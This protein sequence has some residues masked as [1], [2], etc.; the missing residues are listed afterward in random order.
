LSATRAGPPAAD[1]LADRAWSLDATPPADYD[2][3]RP[4]DYAS[5]SLTGIADHF[6]TDKGS[7]KHRYTEVYERYLAPLRARTG[8]RLLE[9]GVACGASLKMWSKYFRDAVVVGVD[10]REGCAG[11]CRGYPAISIRIADARAARQPE[12]FDVIIDDGS[13]IS[14]DIV[15]IFRVNWP[16]L[17]PGGLYFIED[18]KCTHNPLYPR[19]TAIRA[20]PE[21]FERR[22][23]VEFI[24]RQLVEMDWGRGEVESLHFHRELAVLRK[25]QR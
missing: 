23:F 4:I 20:A 5:A 21:R 14:A 16:S 8:V 12:S 7:I 1:A 13:H 2:P 24:D 9:I 3:P 10:L 6:K 25:A 22:H 17:V 18:L 19:Q 15:D 11:L